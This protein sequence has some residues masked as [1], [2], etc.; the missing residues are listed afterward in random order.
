LISVNASIIK[1]MKSKYYSKMM[2]F[3]KKIKIWKNVFVI[4]AKIGIKN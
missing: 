4:V 2:E 1:K 3:R